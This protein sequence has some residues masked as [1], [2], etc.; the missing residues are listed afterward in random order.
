M[1]KDRLI[2]ARRLSGM[3]LRQVVR[4][5]DG[6]ITST[7]VEALESGFRHPTDAELTVL[8]ETY[9]VRLDWLRLDADNGGSSLTVNARGLDGL[10]PNDVAKLIL[11]MRAHRQ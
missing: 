1:I 5:S 7:A 3:S 2:E 6:R 10:A 9:E 8:A 4:F 11:Q